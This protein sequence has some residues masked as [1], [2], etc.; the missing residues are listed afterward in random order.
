MYYHDSKSVERWQEFFSPLMRLLE[1]ECANGHRF[2]M[3]WRDDDS[4]R[5]T[6]EL[7]RLLSAA[8]SV[9]IALSVIPGLL[10]R[11]FVTLVNG[12]DNISILQHGWKHINHSRDDAG[13][14]EFPE[15]RPPSEA[16][17]QLREGLTLLKTHFGDRF[18]T[19][20]VPPWHSCASWLL[21]QLS[22]LGYLAVSRDAPLLPLL[23][24]CRSEEVNIEID[25]S[26]WR[27]Q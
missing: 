16:I 9:P 3:W 20:F 10:E 4:C 14:S 7:R 18:T 12:T 19:V 1:R 22:P 6:P 24:R 27:A 8:A 25:T 13:P 26:N 17:P 15:S 11:D 21:E 23:K 5:D 2:R